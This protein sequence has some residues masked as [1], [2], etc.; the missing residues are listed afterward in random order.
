M[1]K[2]AWLVVTVISMAMFVSLPVIAAGAQVYRW[3]DV[4]GATNYSDNPNAKNINGAE[5]LKLPKV[6]GF[7]EEEQA[8]DDKVAS[9]QAPAEMSD[10]AKKQEEITKDGV[11]CD[12]RVGPSA[13]GKIEIRA[14][15]TNNMPYPAGGVR[16]DVI[17][18]TVDRQRLPDIAM[19]VQNGK[20]KPDWLGPGE[21]VELT[22][23]SEVSMEMYSGH[24]LQVKWA[25]VAKIPEGDKS[26]PGVREVLVN[27][28]TGIAKEVSRNEAAPPKPAAPPPTSEDA[29]KSEP[30]PQENAL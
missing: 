6:R 10:D 15:L 30:E 20:I 3:T 23:E 28:K 8:N 17:L 22:Y 7:E 13:S 25:S 5:Q 12:C 2:L 9:V 16:V 24:N 21:T 29:P 18:Y 14:I 26:G 27:K 19:R 1:R 4:D 11:K